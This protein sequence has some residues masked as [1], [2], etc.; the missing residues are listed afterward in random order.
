ME[1]GYYDDAEEPY[2]VPTAPAFALTPLN[3]AARK[4]VGHANN[5]H[6]RCQSH[7]TIGLWV[8]LSDPDKIFTL[9]RRDTDIHLPD[10]TSSSKGSPCISDLHASFQVVLE[11]GAVLLFD[12]SGNGT[13]E[14][15][16]RDQHYTVKFRSNAKS[17]LVARGINSR[18]AFGK[19]QWYQFEIQWHSDGLYR[20]PKHDPYTM[21]PRNSRHKKYLLGEQVG[22][23]SYGTVWWALDATNGKIIAVKRFHKLAGKNLEFATREMTNLFKINRDDSIKHEHILK[24]LDC[25][26]GGKGDDWG[27]IFM[28]LMQGNLKTLVEK[29]AV[30][31]ERLSDIVLR[32]MLLALQC[33]AEHKIIHRDVKPEN[34]LWEYDET[35]NY[36]FCLGDFGLSNDPSLARTAA[37]TE[38]FMAPEVF[39][40]QKQTTKVDIWS[41]FATIVWTRTPEFRRQ[42]SQL[43]APDLHAWLVQFSK[44]E[45]YANIRGMASW[46]PKKRPSAKK[47]LAILDGQVEDY[48]STGSYAGNS[49][50]EAGEDLNA[51]FANGLSL[52]DPPGLTYASGSS[53]AVTS[54]ELAYYEP[55]ASGILEDY[56]GAQAGPSKRYMPPSPNPADA[57]RQGAW[58]MPYEPPYGPPDGSEGSGTAVPDTWTATAPTVNGD[59]E[60]AD[61]EPSGRHKGKSKV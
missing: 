47:Q 30:P 23:G 41:L 7:D 19:D 14:P 37:G 45:Q 25:A 46:E 18:I 44:L 54:P 36:R 26:G 35:G 9:G 55:Y 60:S 32:Q 21:G 39:H 57:P 8:D 50:D 59:D 51:R 10:K 42:C 56:Y 16:P 15:L 11:T 1:D 13:V 28:P 48:R 40:R 6:L 53:D 31:D 3:P 12:H 49:E 43:H 27:E 38:P 29:A 22:A 20:F 33:I 52:Q 58:V 4:V 34:I 61:G 2:T 17:V 24:I 5:S